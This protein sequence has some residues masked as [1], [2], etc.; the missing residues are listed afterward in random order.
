MKPGARW[1]HSAVPESQHTVAARN[2]PTAAAPCTPSTPL[3]SEGG[4]AH[5]AKLADKLGGRIGGRVERVCRPSGSAREARRNQRWAGT[6]VGGACRH[7]ETGGEERK[8]T[9]PT[10]SRK[11]AHLRSADRPRCP[12]CR[13]QF[14]ASWTIKGAGWAGQR[15][16]QRSGSGRRLSCALLLLLRWRQARGLQQ[17]PPACP[18][19]PPSHRLVY[20]ASLNRPLE[21]EVSTNGTPGSTD[22]TACAK[23]R[24]RS[25]RR[26]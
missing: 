3:A 7:L 13:Q 4:Q 26:R 16:G 8:E 21:G 6:Q 18:T 10:H 11:N 15:G 5:E 9:H 19:S 23:Q 22:R 1:A 14:G 24:G 2:P 25:G 12:T 17:R 20:G